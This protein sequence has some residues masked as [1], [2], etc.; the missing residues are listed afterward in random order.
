M[1]Y[2]LEKFYRIYDDGEGVCIEVRPHP[3]LPE[4]LIE[5]NTRSNQASKEFYGDVSLT[6]TDKQA[7]FLGAALIE[8]SKTMQEKH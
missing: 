4:S 3:D 1:S 8:I 6:L 2:T 7:G 5:L